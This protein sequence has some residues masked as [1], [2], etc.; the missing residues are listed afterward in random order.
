[1]KTNKQTKKQRNKYNERI[2][3]VSVSTEFVYLPDYLHIFLQI[4]SFISLFF[5]FFFTARLLFWS[6]FHSCT[7]DNWKIFFYC[8]RWCECYICSHV[9]CLARLA[10]SQ[11]AWLEITFWLSENQDLPYPFI[12]L[13][14]RQCK[15][16]NYHPSKANSPL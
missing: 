9:L 5:L 2:K 12:L 10:F 14:E 13:Y 7:Y 11:A 6:V 1:M 8:C 3:R 16:T 4:F 15:S